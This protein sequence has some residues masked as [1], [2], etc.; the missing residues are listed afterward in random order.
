M[1][2]IEAKHSQIII[3]FSKINNKPI[4]P[5]S[6]TE[7]KGILENVVEIKLASCIRFIPKKNHTIKS[8]ITPK[9]RKK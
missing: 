5:I 6:K 4:V 1:L 7:I 3:A 2:E 8:R 9:I